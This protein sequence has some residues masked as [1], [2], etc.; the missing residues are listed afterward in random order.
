MR[1]LISL[2]E[3]SIWS[4]TADTFFMRKYA[5]ATPMMPVTMMSLPASPADASVEASR[6]AMHWRGVIVSAV[7]TSARAI[8][9]REACR[10]PRTP[11]G[12][13]GKHF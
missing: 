10:L 3:P 8:T 9:D 12:R 5:N 4:R 1:P 6:G 13:A 11:Q 2:L 7:L